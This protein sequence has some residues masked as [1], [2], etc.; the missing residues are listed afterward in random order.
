VLVRSKKQPSVFKTLPFNIREK[1][2]RFR[3][4][5]IRESLQ[6]D[7]KILGKYIGGKSPNYYVSFKFDET[8]L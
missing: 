5:H 8:G 2:K 4:P 3:G 6:I 7:F 1:K